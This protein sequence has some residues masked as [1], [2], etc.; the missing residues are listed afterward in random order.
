MPTLETRTLINSNGCCL[1]ISN[2]GATIISLK[3]PNK[4]QE[5]IDVIVGLSTPEAYTQSPYIEQGLYLGSTIGRYAGRISDSKK[6]NLLKDSQLIFKDG[7]HLHGGRN[8]FDKKYWI[9]EKQEHPNVVTLSYLSKH[10]EEGYPGNLKVSVTYTLTEDNEVCITYTATTDAP[11]YINL[12]NHSYFNLNGSGS[13]LDHHLYIASDHYLEV[14]TNLIPTG[15]YTL[16]SNNKY[17]RTESSQI[18][19]SDFT[20]YDD[21]FILKKSLNH[22]IKASLYA[23]KTG[24]QM[25]VYTN[26]PAIVV[27]T[28][29][30]FPKLD[31]K[32]NVIYTE[33]PAICF[34]NQHFSDAPNH[35]HFPSTLLHPGIIYKN[36]SRYTFSIVD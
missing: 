35:T 30:V 2:Y 1:E 18:G 4:H 22:I 25:E 14:D 24:I 33:Y 19:R 8:G 16:T 23:P 31:F 9:L 28:P 21:T 17:D 13:I 27:Y 7:V 36:E 3:I 15:N 34:E 12:T 26:Q 10:L 11:T 5:L 6:N 20:G 32:N 29:K